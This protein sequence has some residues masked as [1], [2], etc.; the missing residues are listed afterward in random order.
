MVT[1]AIL[2]VKLGFTDPI[3]NKSNQSISCQTGIISIQSCNQSQFENLPAISKCHNH[4]KSGVAGG[5][6]TCLAKT[7]V[8]PPDCVKI[9]FHTANPPYSH[10]AGSVNGIFCAL[11]VITNYHT[12]SNGCS[13]T[14]SNGPTQASSNGLSQARRTAKHHTITCSQPFSLQPFQILILIIP[15]STHPMISSVMNQTNPGQK[16]HKSQHHLTRPPKLLTAPTRLPAPSIQPASCACTTPGIQPPSVPEEN[17]EVDPL[18]APL[19][20]LRSTPSISSFRCSPAGT[21]GINRPCQTNGN[22]SCRGT[23]EQPASNA[24]SQRASSPVTSCQNVSSRHPIY[25]QPGHKLF[26][27]FSNDCV[28]LRLRPILIA[29]PTWFISISVNPLHQ[30]ATI[31]IVLRSYR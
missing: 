16:P 4:I 31:T 27:C 26:A 24:Q 12:P 25:T 13:Q 28:S 22:F 17:G 20:K 15:Q 23:L 18:V 1:T 6:A 8:S 30:K 7:F 11:V 14:P 21:T 2:Y 5:I 10:Y 3:S 29:R 19:E 9:F